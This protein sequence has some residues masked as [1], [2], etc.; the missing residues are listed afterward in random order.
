MVAIP[1]AM[2]GSTI[3]WKICNSP[4]PSILAASRSAFDS[5]DCTYCLKKN[6]VPGDAI[7]GMMSGR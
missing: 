6:T 5:V 4:A 7:A 2:I 3:L 1:G